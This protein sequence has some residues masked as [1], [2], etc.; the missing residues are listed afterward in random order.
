[1]VDSG[2]EFEKGFCYSVLFSCGLPS[3]DFTYK[4]NDRGKYPN[5]GVYNPK[6]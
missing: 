4:S 5:D 6:E 1:M 2:Q 3:L